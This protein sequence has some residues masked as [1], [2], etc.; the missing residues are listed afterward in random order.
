MNK[1]FGVDDSNFKANEFI[2]QIIN[3]LEELIIIGFYNKKSKSLWFSL[4][5]QRF[6]N[7]SY[8][9]QL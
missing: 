3:N 5:R 6:G 4:L 9:Y 7:R 2:C 8:H 1:Y